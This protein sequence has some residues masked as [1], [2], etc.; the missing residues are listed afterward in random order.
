MKKLRPAQERDRSPV[1]LGAFQEFE[2]RV[3]VQVHRI[4]EQQPKSVIRRICVAL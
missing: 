2:R 3:E 4:A 1:Y